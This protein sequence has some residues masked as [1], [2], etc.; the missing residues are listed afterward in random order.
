MARSGHPSRCRRRLSVESKHGSSFD[1]LVGA[2]NEGGAEP[3]NDP[4]RACEL[5]AH[6]L[7]GLLL[8][9][10]RG[11][12]RLGDDCRRALAAGRHHL[13][14]VHQIGTAVFHPYWQ[15]PACAIVQTQ[16][17]A[18]WPQSQPVPTQMRLL[19]STLTSSFERKVNARRQNLVSVIV[20]EELGAKMATI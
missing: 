16:H 5:I 1:H 10:R 8:V 2:S 19:I 13:A 18:R 14:S 15:R 17:L 11:Y 4:I 20:E 7:A 12:R 6:A 3:M 9:A